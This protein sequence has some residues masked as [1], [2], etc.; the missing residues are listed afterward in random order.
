MAIQNFIDWARVDDETTAKIDPNE[1]KLVTNLGKP[2]CTRYIRLHCNNPHCSSPHSN[3]PTYDRGALHVS[4]AFIEYNQYMFFCNAIFPVQWM[5]KYET[6]VYE[7]FLAYSVEKKVV[8]R[9]DLMR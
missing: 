4:G 1:A 2:I 8:H 7:L 9:T 5:Y 6:Y 3:N